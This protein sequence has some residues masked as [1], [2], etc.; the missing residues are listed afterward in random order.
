MLNYKELLIW[1]YE[2]VVLAGI[3]TGKYFDGEERLSDLIEKIL[4]DVPKLKRLRLSSIEINEIDD[5]L[6]EIMKKIIR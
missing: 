1:G 2:E 3:H 4:K 5:K 6:L